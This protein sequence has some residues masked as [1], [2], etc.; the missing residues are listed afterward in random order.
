MSQWLLLYTEAH[1]WAAVVV[2]MTM[3]VSCMAIHRW[4]NKHTCFHPLWKWKRDTEAEPESGRW[5]AVRVGWT[6]K[7]NVNINISLLCRNEH[8][9][10]RTYTTHKTNFIIH[11]LSKVNCELSEAIGSTAHTDCYFGGC[12]W[13][14]V[15]S[16]KEFWWLQWAMTCGRGMVNA[17]NDLIRTRF[18]LR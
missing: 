13:C 16:Q 6:G 5:S 2:M 18:V 3:M 14:A 7:V 4:H 15:K 8:T 12:C 1:I 9:H 11:S 10:H 17:F